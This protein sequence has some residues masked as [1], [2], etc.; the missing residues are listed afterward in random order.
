MFISLS[1]V[2]GVKAPA[3]EKMVKIRLVLKFIY[4]SGAAKLLHQRH[5]MQIKSLLK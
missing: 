3:S 1:T 5:W 2:P 4:V